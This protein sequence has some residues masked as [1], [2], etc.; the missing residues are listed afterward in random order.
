V[1]AFIIEQQARLSPATANQRYRSLAQLF[2]F[3]LDE[4][5]ITASPMANMRAAPSAGGAGA[6]SSATPELRLL[7][8][9]ADGKSFETAPRHGVAPNVHRHRCSPIGDRR[10]SW[11]KTSTGTIQARPG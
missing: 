6:Q 1:E 4:G 7:L 10:S 3:L 2:K 5:E 11:S 9:A 8:D